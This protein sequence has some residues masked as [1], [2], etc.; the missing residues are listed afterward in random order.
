[1]HIRHVRM[2][3]SH[4]PVLVRMCVGFTG[5]IT[6][7]MGVLVMDVMRVRMRVHEVLVKMLVLVMLR[8]V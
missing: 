8:E 7:L 4:W 6:N 5:W 2:R 3:V 1:M